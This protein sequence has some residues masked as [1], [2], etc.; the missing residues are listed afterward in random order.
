MR[1]VLANTAVTD[2]ENV[3]TI[4]LKAEVDRDYGI[5]EEGERTI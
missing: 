4:H 3:A 2:N 1:E 5:D